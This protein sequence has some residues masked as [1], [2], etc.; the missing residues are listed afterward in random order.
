MSQ[1]DESS[2][3]TETP[4]NGGG[5]KTGGGAKPGVAQKPAAAQRP[6][7]AAAVGLAQVNP[8]L[9]RTLQSVARVAAKAPARAKRQ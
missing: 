7:A 1:H 2:S 6:G 9:R 8:T 3:G 4:D 5:A